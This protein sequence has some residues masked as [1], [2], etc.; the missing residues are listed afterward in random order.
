[1]RI[2]DC[3]SDVC[4]SDLPAD[5]RRYCALD[6]RLGRLANPPSADP[7]MALASSGGRRLQLLRRP[8]VPAARRGDFP[9]LRGAPVHYR[10]L[11][12]AAASS[13]EHTFEPQSLMRIAYAV[14]CLTKQTTHEIETT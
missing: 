10:A 4:S 6:R 9:D 7:C 11:G 13:E 2:S 14:F 5:D 3:S 12:A 1:M 8:Q